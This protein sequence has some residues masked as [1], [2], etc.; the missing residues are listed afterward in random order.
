MT[1]RQRLRASEQE[2]LTKKLA[3]AEAELSLL[4][5]PAAAS[6]Y[7]GTTGADPLLAL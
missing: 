2:D 3:Q 4:S 1:A 6:R 5:E 7:F